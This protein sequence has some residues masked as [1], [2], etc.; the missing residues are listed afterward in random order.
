MN[1]K[2]LLE[3]HMTQNDEFKH[4][5]MKTNSKKLH[6]ALCVSGK[7]MFGCSVCKVALCKTSKE[8]S[9]KSDNC[10]IIWHKHADLIV[11]HNKIRQAYRGSS[12]ATYRLPLSNKSTSDEDEENVM[13]QDGDNADEESIGAGAPTRE[14]KCLPK[15]QLRA[16][17]R[18]NYSQEE[19]SKDSSA[20]TNPEEEYRNTVL[21]RIRQRSG[22]PFDIAAMANL[23]YIRK[24]KQDCK[25]NDS[26]EDKEADEFA[27]LPKTNL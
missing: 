27:G 22:N 25:E 10:F 4:I 7:T 19:E 17:T 9:H 1:R 3:L 24:G 18:K 21:A 14:T 8:R 5:L 16:N 2:N 26:Y 12:N 20:D 15:R 23:S 13:G 11:E 6:C